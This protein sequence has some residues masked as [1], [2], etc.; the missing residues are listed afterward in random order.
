MIMNVPPGNGGI[1]VDGGG[2]TGAVSGTTIMASKDAQGNF[3]FMVLEGIGT[4]KVTARDG[5]ITE[6]RPGQMATLAAA[7]GAANVVTV[8]LDAMR[9]ISPLFSEFASAMPGNEEI[10][11][12]ADLQA[13]DIQRELSS[14]QGPDGVGLNGLSPALSALSALSG[15]SVSTVLGSNNLLIGDPS[16]AAGKESGSGQSSTPLYVSENSGPNDSRQDSAKALVASSLPSPSVG[17]T[18]TAAGG[19]EDA[20]G[21]DTAAGGNAGADTQAPRSPLAAPTPAQATPT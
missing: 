17:N 8:N 7:G 20:A 1:I 4:G 16:T 12:V 6:V 15:L 14:L 2:V 9:D 19:G 3:S 18:D 11:A 5:T 13:E 21:T 10:Q